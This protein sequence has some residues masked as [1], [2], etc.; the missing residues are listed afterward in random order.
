MNIFC[1]QA[2]RLSA[3]QDE[4]KTTGQAVK[5]KLDDAEQE[6]DNLKQELEAKKALLSATHQQLEEKSTLLQES[7]A[8][9][10]K[11]D[12][13]L[14]G[15]HD[16]VHRMGDEHAKQIQHIHKEK[17]DQVKKCLQSLTFEREKHEGTPAFQTAVNNEPNADVGN[18]ADIHTDT[19]EMHGDG[20]DNCEED[21]NADS[22]DDESV[23]VFL[24]SA[25]QDQPVF[26]RKS[27]KQKLLQQQ[28]QQQQQQRPKSILRVKSS[29]QID[30][31]DEDES[32][33]E[34]AIEQQSTLA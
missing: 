19:V 16:V 10:A 28:Q 22:Q 5:H 20:D 29:A 23:E 34:T 25:R 32:G 15:M 9:V 30:E 24:N 3:P 12:S 4:L 33:M 17:E 2:Y 27:R 26:T 21:P 31:S 14:A 13:D 18:V 7:E 1:V 6:N 11:L 8:K